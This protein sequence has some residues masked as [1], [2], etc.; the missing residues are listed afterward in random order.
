MIIKTMPAILNTLFLIF[1]LYKMTFSIVSRCS[2]SHYKTD[3]TN[4]FSDLKTPKSNTNVV[5]FVIF[6]LSTPLLLPRFHS[7]KK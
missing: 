1:A 7:Y 2:F 6:S 4:E 5:I 3:I